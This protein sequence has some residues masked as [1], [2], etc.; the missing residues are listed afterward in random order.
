MFSIN[1]SIIEYLKWFGKLKVSVVVPR[2]TR[3]R[4]VYILVMDGSAHQLRG[5]IRIRRGRLKE[6][7]LP[8]QPDSLDP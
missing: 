3:V 4:F 8:F 6:T 7:L 2:F 1:T 5:G